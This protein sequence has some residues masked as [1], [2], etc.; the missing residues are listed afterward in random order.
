MRNLSIELLRTLVAI[1]QRDTFAAAATRIGRTQSAI[2]QQMQ[3]LE[4][5]LGC[6]LFERRGR[7]KALTPEGVRLVAY[8][9]KIL[10]LNDQAVQIMSARGP[11]E[12]IRLGSPHDVAD[13]ILPN[14]LRQLSKLSP[15][16][17]MEIDVGRSPF[18]MTALRE[19][20]LDMAISTRYDDAFPGIKL[21]TSPMVWICAEDFIFNTSAPVPLVMADELSLF[22]QRSVACLDANHVPWR[23][24][25][26]SP[27]LTGIKAA[28]R[29][30]LGV[31]ARTTELLDA[32]MRV[33][34]EADGLPRLPDVAFYLYVQPTCTSSVLRELFDSVDHL[35]TR[36]GPAFE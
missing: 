1:A 5:E 22:R 18:L 19:N 23:T 3:R 14:L 26:M 32:N 28:I 11:A 4:Q 33:L 7:H 2:T 8:A 17:Q 16:L 36:F 12:K 10:A 35:A 21:R 24:S 25:Y 29:A 13:S 27:T 20:E 6:Q 15:D 31:T 34:S 9:Y 30:G